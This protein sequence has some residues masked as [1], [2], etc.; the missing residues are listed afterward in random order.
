ME[1]DERVPHTAHID[2]EWMQR[3]L[4]NYLE[5][6]VKYVP[7]GRVRFAIFLQGDNL[8]F[9]V[10]DN[11]PGIPLRAQS[12]LFDRF[13][14]VPGQTKAGVGLGLSIAREIV[15]AHGG[16]VGVRSKLG[17]GSEFYF[18]LEAVGEAE[19]KNGQGGEIRAPDRL[20]PKQV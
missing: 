20:H 12:R 3:A 8:H 6:A 14:R 9:E 17:K 4:H 2:R 1:L 13:Y 5:N 16:R 10:V 7:N 11:G 15:V 19:G 18:V